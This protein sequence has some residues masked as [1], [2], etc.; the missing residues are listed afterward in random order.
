[1]I[2]TLDG[3]GAEKVL[4]NLVN[5]LPREKY[6][7]TVAALF[8]GGANRRFLKDDIEYIYLFKKVFRGN[9]I[10][11]KLLSPELVYK[12]LVGERKFELVVSYLEGITARVVSG[13][14]DENTKKLC[15]IHRELTP[16]FYSSPFKSKEEADRI[17]SSYDKIVCVAKGL[18]QS[19]CSFN[20]LFEKTV[21]LYNVNE[22][23]KIVEK[24]KERSDEEYLSGDVTKICFA[25]KLIENKGVPVLQR[26]HERLC[27]ENVPH[28]FVLVGKGPLQKKIGREL[29]EKGIEKDFV[30][31]GYQTNPYR[32]ISRCDIFALPSRFEGFSTAVT[33]ALV[34]G[35]PCV[36]TDCSGMKELLGEN[37]EFG[38]VA[39]D[40]EAFYLALKR[41][42]TD[43]NQREHYAAAALERGK[44]FSLEETV[45]AH[46]ALFDELTEEKR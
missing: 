30:F 36:V 40:E 3:G 24:A 38:V 8:D 4:V 33:E 41:M 12:R 29:A 22:T 19:F 20:G 1:M 28:R 44:R 23:Q 39:K 6:Q 13:C 25:G 2:H 46:V 34:L 42:I 17:Y 7:I 31:A 9:R 43:R 45:A 37:D 15:W 21:C 14:G 11:F 10:L 16:L 32:F 5:N 35:K 27:E 18:V 26:A